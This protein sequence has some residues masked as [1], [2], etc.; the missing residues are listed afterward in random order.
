P[1]MATDEVISTED[2]ELHS[3]PGKAPGLR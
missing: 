3:S 1:G 2:R